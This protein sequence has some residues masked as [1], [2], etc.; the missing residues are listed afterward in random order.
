[1]WNIYKNLKEKIKE[2]ERK[3][4]NCFDNK[5]FLKSLSNELQSDLYRW[6]FFTILDIRIY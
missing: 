6:I 4:E 3:D 1:M 5:N 2:S